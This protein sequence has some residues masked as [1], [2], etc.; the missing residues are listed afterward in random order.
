MSGEWTVLFYIQRLVFANYTNKNTYIVTTLNKKTS[1]QRVNMYNMN[2]A[3]SR[4]ALKNGLP[5]HWNYI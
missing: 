3:L 1:S 2:S 5:I 4:E